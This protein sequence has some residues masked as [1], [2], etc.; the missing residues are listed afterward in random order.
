MKRFLLFSIC[1]FSLTFSQAQLVE[2]GNATN[3]ITGPL[4]ESELHVTDWEVINAS[5]ET[6]AFGC[7][8]ISVYD[9][10]GSLNQFC[11]GILCSAWGTG[12]LTSSQVV[13]LAPGAYSNSFYA[14]YR[15]NGNAGQSTV[16]YCWFD[17]NNPSNE[18]CYD[19][20]YCVE[21]E[22]II[23]VRENTAVGQISGISPNPINGTGNISYNFLS[24]PSSG[25][26]SIY[27]MM[28]ELV[29][30][31]PLT[32]KNGSVFISA[33]D[34]ASGIYFC[35]IENEGKVFETKRFVIAK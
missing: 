11:W 28:G 6:I 12:N 27:N 24:P 26:M 33:T 21:G 18:Y 2:L 13:N 15:H 3:Q 4:S 14:H 20:N 32:K 23:G 16:R 22:C 19:V 5:N 34:Y 30:Q 25:K 35:N 8:R 9:V 1:I 29:K 7:K 17:T 10:P 31:V